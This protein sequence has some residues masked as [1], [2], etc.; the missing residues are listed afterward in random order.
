M[1][2]EKIYWSA[3]YGALQRTCSQFSSKGACP[4]AR[5]RVHS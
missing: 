1:N 4:A 5:G 2:K 3:S